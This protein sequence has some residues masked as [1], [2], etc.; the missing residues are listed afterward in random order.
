MGSNI[1]V[2]V[3]ES[4]TRGSDDDNESDNELEDEKVQKSPNEDI[5]MN[6]EKATKDAPAEVHADY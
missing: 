6:N 3:P 2:P 5:A 1:S 4:T